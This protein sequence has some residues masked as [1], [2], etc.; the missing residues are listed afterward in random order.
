MASLAICLHRAGSWGCLLPQFQGALAALISPALQRNVTEPARSRT[1]SAQKLCAV[2][3][4]EVTFPT[5]LGAIACPSHPVSCLSPAEPSA[6]IP[7]SWAHGWAGLCWVQPR[8]GTPPA[9]RGDAGQEWIHLLT[10]A[11]LWPGIWPSPAVP[12]LQLEQ[13]LDPAPVEH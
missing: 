9:G 10:S 11:C 8:S 7:S 1:E 2:L 13:G 5:L 3:F 4:S 12:P 6:S